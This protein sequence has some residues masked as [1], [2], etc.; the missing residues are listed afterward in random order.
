MVDYYRINRTTTPEKSYGFL[1]EKRCLLLLLLFGIGVSAGFSQDASRP[2]APVSAGVA[3]SNITPDPGVI[4]WVNQKPYGK[5]LDSLYA[6]VLVLQDTR[7]KAVIISVDLLEAGESFTSEVRKAVSAALGISENNILVNASHSHSAP[8]SPV[9]GDSYRQ[10][11]KRDSWWHISQDDNPHYRRWKA[12]LVT[13]IAKAAREADAAAVPVD[14]RI[15]RADVSAFLVNR[16]PRAAAWGVAEDS[17]PKAFN[18][19]YP[20]WD[21]AVMVGGKTFGPLDPSMTIVSFR[22]QSGNNVASIFHLSCHAVSVYPYE[23]GLSADWP[24]EASRRM[25]QALGG[26]FLFLLGAG[27]DIN[28]W[29]RGLDA[30][31]VMADGLTERAR[32]AYRYSVKLQT[33]PLHIKRTTIGLPLNPYGKQH[34]GLEKLA[35]DVQVVACGPLALVALPGELLTDIGQAIRDKSPF[36]QTLVL[37]YSNGYGVI[38]VGMPGEKERGGYEMEDKQ[39]L[40]TDLAGEVLVNTALKL[41]NEVYKK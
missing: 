27:G 2:S 23:D 31:D 22:N 26:E 12:G 13:G 38:Y 19:R 33:S 29:K 15:G 9:Y 17:T 35:G 11:M 4:N 6:R 5:I 8:W 16:R 3:R 25:S 40:G 1:N 37:G 20:D 14:I 10:V 21:P 18:F 30:V 28:P 34:T 36:P 7:Q 39:S 32:A 41:L 24:G